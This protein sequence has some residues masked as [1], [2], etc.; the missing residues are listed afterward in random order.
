MY[1]YDKY[2]ILLKNTKP[3]DFFFVTTNIWKYMNIL[4]NQKIYV[5]TAL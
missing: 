2:V 1:Y 5:R 3:L 4:I